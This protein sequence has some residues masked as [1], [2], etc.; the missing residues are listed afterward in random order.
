VP[1]I[2]S[3]LVTDSLA[4]PGMAFT[5]SA[6]INTPKYANTKMAAPL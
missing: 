6:T 5:A 3:A 2:A 1:R 4:Q